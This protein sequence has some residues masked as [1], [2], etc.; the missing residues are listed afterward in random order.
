MEMAHMTLTVHIHSV[1]LSNTVLRP[2][3]VFLC[4]TTPQPYTEIH[5]FTHIIALTQISR[6]PKI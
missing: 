1:A 3:D 5:S 2:T 4:P 6:D